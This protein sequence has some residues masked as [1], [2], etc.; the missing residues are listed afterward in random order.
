MKNEHYPLGLRF[1]LSFA[2]L[3]SILAAGQISAQVTIRDSISVRPTVTNFTDRKDN[4]STTLT[5]CSFPLVFA[6]GFSHYHGH[7]G[8]YDNEIAT[9]ELVV[10]GPC[11]EHGSNQASAAA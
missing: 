7:E 10:V 9:E 5:E 4:I 11:G 8:N 2:F 6:L 3:L 1:G